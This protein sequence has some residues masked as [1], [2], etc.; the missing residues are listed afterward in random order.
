LLL[1]VIKAGDVIYC[2]LRRSISDD[3]VCTAVT[4]TPPLL[5]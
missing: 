4:I 5:D 1:S 3:I 2:Q